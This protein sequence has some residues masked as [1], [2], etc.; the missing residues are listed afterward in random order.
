MPFNFNHGVPQTVMA[1]ALGSVLAASAAE[2]DQIAHPATPASPWTPAASLS[3]KESFDDNVYLQDMGPNANRESLITTITPSLGL[4]YKPSA[5]FGASLNYTP[6][7]NL[8]D[9]AASENFTTQRTVLALGGKADNTAWEVTENFIG[10]DGSKVGPTYLQPGGAPADGGPAVRDRRAALVERGQFRLTQSFGQWF[11]RPVVTG[12]LHDFLEEHQ[13]TKGYQNF[14]N[15]S[16]LNGG[17]DL[18]WTGIKDTS[19]VVGYRYGVQSQDQLYPDINA[20]YYN[21][22][23]QRVLFG[24]EGK[25]WSW[26]KL[27]LSAGPEFRYYDGIVAA[28][29]NRN[30]TYCYIDSSATI[31]VTTNDTVTLQAISF[32]QPGFAG[33]STY[34]DTALDLAWKHNLTEKLTIGAGIHG[35]NND[36]I[37]PSAD[38]NDWIVTEKGTIAYAFSKEFSAEASYLYDNATSEVPNTPARAYFRQCVLLGIKYVFR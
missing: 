27:N 21:N 33:R 28:G 15:R 17:A 5:A 29:F 35:S 25:P 36:F 18:G 19:L 11:I 31:T 26:L 4:A 13:T 32:E 9:S 38:R 37:K 34:L 22:H 16:D 14:A 20:T 6:E 30:Q 3:L 7:I 10:I 23:Y 24:V 8:F 1:I 2:P 12:Y